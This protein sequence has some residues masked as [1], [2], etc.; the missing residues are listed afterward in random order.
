M[1]F[2]TLIRR[3]RIRISFNLSDQQKL[4][5]LIVDE[6]IPP[7][8]MNFVGEGD[9]KLIGDAYL[10]KFKKFGLKPDHHVLDIGCG[11]GRMAIPMTQYLDRN[12]RYEG[13]DIREDGIQW[14]REKI[15]P[16]YPAFH[17]K[18]TPLRNSQYLPDEEAE[19][20]RFS[21]PYA[22]SR[23]DFVIATSVFT[24]LEQAVVCR[25]LDEINRVLKPSGRMAATFFL[26][27]RD[28]KPHQLRLEQNL[29]FPHHFGHYRLQVAENPD[30]AVAYEES[31]VTAQCER[32]GLQ[33]RWP[34]RHDFQDIIVAE[35][36][37]SLPLRQRWREFR[38]RCLR[39]QN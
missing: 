39:R 23:F 33:I 17:F 8:E 35:K 32:R 6:M 1:C 16:R 36:K 31:W 29:N 12:G 26:Y 3:L 7:L 37:R 2:H 15:T 28:S 13:F 18:H 38:R 14:C 9:F 25:Y 21:F 11:L 10:E 30:A 20:A 4:T 34:V 22:S 19:P 27:S 24:H 5:M